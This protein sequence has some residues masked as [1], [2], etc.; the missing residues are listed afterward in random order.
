MVVTAFSGTSLMAMGI[1]YATTG[2]IETAQVLLQ[3][4]ATIPTGVSATWI[5]WIILHSTL[6]L[7]NQYLLQVSICFVLFSN[8]FVH[9]FYSSLFYGLLVMNS[10][11]LLSSNTSGGIVVQD[12]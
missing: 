10:L 1:T 6:I 11:I 5:N 8:T 7:P 4:A 2:Q 3:I 9:Q 12:P